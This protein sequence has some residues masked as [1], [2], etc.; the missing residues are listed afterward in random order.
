MPEE[1]MNNSPQQPTS[2]EG[3]EQFNNVNNEALSQVANLE[4]STQVNSEELSS[5]YGS[6]SSGPIGEMPMTETPPETVFEDTSNIN[7]QATSEAISEAPV[8]SNNT[9]STNQPSNGFAADPVVNNE[10]ESEPTP[11]PFM[12]PESLPVQSVGSEPMLPPNPEV[13]SKNKL[14]IPT[15]IAVIVIVVLAVAGY[16]LAKYLF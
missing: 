2:A 1:P 16:F 10:P 13:S 12:A 5:V 15:L 9:E 4:D 3:A 8:L 11:Q 7:A 14:I 6:P